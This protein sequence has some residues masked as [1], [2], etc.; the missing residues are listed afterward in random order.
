MQQVVDGDSLRLVDGRKVRLIGIN[1]PELGRDGKP[2]EPLSVK[3]RDALEKIIATHT[4]TLKMGPDKTDHYG[5]T[6][7]YVMLPDG[8]SAGEKCCKWGWPR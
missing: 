5:R 1:T 2:D 6:L 7:A 8:S 4:I 3:A